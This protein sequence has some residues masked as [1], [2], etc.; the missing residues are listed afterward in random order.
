M[1]PLTQTK[2]LRVLQEQRFERVGGNETVQT[3][4]RLVAATNMDLERAVESGRFR[5][6]LYYRL[7][8]YAISLP[9]LRD[10]GDDIP[11]LVE[12]FMKR[13][14][15]ELGKDA[16]HLAPEAMEL[17]Q[18]YPW[19]GNLRELQSVLKHALLQTTGPVV[20][21][22]CLPA[23]LRSHRAA[24]EQP[25][26]APQ[27]HPESVWESFLEE[28]LQAGS[29]DLYAEWQSLTERLLFE[30]VLR[31][32]QGNFS[33]AAKILGIHRITLRTKVAA[34]GILPDAASAA[35]ESS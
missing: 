20:S 14:R 15:K 11:L 16:G 1:T 24:A 17:L 34:L 2:I 19:P 18:A 33:K 9:P 27:S 6:D 4:V 8:V 12:H 31:H 10:R 35:S 3:D 26:F 5:R 21:R 23:S 7:N 32:T 29:T 28:R 22:D 25:S 13:I 30:R